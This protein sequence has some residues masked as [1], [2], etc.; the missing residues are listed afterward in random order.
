M[1]NSPPRRREARGTSGGCYFGASTS[2]PLTISTSQT[3][4]HPRS[5]VLRPSSA[6]RS[7]RH[8]VHLPKIDQQQPVEVALRREGTEPG[9]EPGA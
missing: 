8:S 7:L 2:L 5:S 6:P 9:C 3:L 4:T 1:I